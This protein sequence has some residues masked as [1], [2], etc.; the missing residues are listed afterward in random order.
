MGVVYEA[1]QLSLNRVVALKMLH[2][3]RLSSSGPLLRFRQEAEAVAALD[4]PNILPVYEVG[5]LQGQPYFTMKLAER[6]HL[7]AGHDGT[8]TQRAVMA[9]RVGL[10]AQVA[11]AVHYAHQRGIQHR[12]LKPHNIL[13]DANGR[14]YVADFGLAKFED[15]DDALTLSTDIIGSPAYMSPEQASGDTRNLTTATDIY[16]L[17]AILYQLLAGRP[18]FVAST[19]PALLRQ[20]VDD[21]PEATGLRDPDLRTI[22]LKCLH[23]EPA[24]RYSSAEQLA[25]ELERWQRG[26]PVLARPASGLERAARWCRRKPALAASLAALLVALAAGVAGVTLQWRRAEEHAR[27]REVERYA[28]DL[29]VASQALG[30][31]DLGLA[32]R[33]LAAQIPVGRDPD[34]RGFEWYFLQDLCRGQ[35]LQVLTGHTATVTC[36]AVSPDGT[37]AASGGMDSMIRIWELPSGRCLTNLPTHRGVVWSVGFTPDSQGLITAG[38]DRKVRVW[39]RAGRPAGPPL[40]GMNAALARNGSRIAASMSSPFRYFPADQGVRVWDWPARRLVFATNLA[41][42]RVALSPDGRWLAAGAERRGIHLWDLQ[43]GDSTLLDCDDTPWALQFSPDGRRLAAAGFNLGARIW[44]LQRRMEPSIALGG[45]QFKVWGVAFS[46][47]SK[48]LATCGSDRTLQL[49]D[50]AA[51]DRATILDGHDDEVWDVT[52]MPDGA[53]L[54]SASKDMTLRTWPDQP[55][56]ARS[57]PSRYHWTPRFSRSGRRLLTLNDG[58]NSSTRLLLSDI[59]TRQSVAE[60]GYRWIGGFGENGEDVVSVNEDTF[61]LE[62]WDAKQGRVGPPLKLEGQKPDRTCR[63]SA[64]ASDGSALALAFDRE[65]GVWDLRSGR[66]RVTIPRSPESPFLAMALSPHGN[67]L[68]YTLTSP[69]TIWLHEIPSGRARQLTIHTEEVKGLAFSSD[70]TMLASA[71]VDRVIRLW[72]TRDG[73]PVGELIRYFQEATDVAFSPDGRLLASVGANQSMDLWHLPTLR[74]VASVAMPGAFDRI[75][76]APTGDALGVTV[77]PG[78]IQVFQPALPR[79]PASP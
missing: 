51:P 11:R 14:P 12:D 22:C 52:W 37:R 15:R 20:I 17:G 71:G 61:E 23:K 44:D 32:R 38:A 7:G 76:F 59:E 9:T 57:F 46:P 47:D 13:I 40:D 65:I 21:D 67:H 42:R 19:V 78:L 2:P 60:F 26:E 30:G 25:E 63:G 3:A 43:T 5:A 72:R 36:T 55:A 68:A 28:A 31:H 75:A 29:Q 33:M 6:G 58:P 74:Q 64:F 49:R 27:H 53:H 45:H 62:R 34:L 4:H 50:L 79:L 24:R 35:H 70:E 10:V 73:T 1:R 69:Y 39:D 66:C 41:V 48:R 16:G 56:A 77:E 54:L 8:A 18:P